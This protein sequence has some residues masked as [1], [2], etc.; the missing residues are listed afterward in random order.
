MSYEIVIKNSKIIEK[1]LIQLGGLG[2]GL[3]DDATSLEGKLDEQI[4]KKIRYVATVRN[5]LIHEDN[6]ELTIDDFNSYRNACNE[7]IKALNI[8]VEKIELEKSRVYLIVCPHCNKASTP[9]LIISKNYNV[10]YDSKCMLCLNTIKTFNKEFKTVEVSNAE[11]MKSVLSALSFIKWF[12]ITN[13]L[14]YALLIF[15]NG[16][17]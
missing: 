12:F 15:L 4:I 17:I 11:F 9:E 8:D 5:K 14:N 3:H 7:I 2:N 13:T 6:F 1:K 16:P 10:Q